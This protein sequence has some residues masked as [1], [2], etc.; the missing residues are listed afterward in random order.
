[1]IFLFNQNIKIMIKSIRLFLFS[2]YALIE[3]FSRAT[4]FDA[5]QVSNYPVDTM[6]PYINPLIVAITTTSP[7]KTAVFLVPITL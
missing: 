2:Q 3:R 4:F 5:S 7:T 6:E 1:M